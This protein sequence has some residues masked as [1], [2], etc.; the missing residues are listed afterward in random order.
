MA[1][2][3]PLTELMDAERLVYDEKTVRMLLKRYRI[4]DEHKFAMW[5]E[6]DRRLGT[7]RLTL[8]LFLEFFPTFPMILRTER[9]SRITKKVSVA[10]LFAEFGKTILVRMYETNYKHCVPNINPKPFGLVFDWPHVRGGLVIHNHPIDT[11]VDGTRLLW[12]SK[13]GQLVVETLN[14]LLDTLDSE[15]PG[16]KG[17]Q[18]E[19]DP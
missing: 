4:S 19:V 13:N 14:V 16:G 2:R 18:P 12:T 9:F 15:V 11:R 1:R 6:S 8:E 5:K 17:W 10:D 7:K 3:E